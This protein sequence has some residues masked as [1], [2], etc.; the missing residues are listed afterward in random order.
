MCPIASKDMDEDDGA[1]EA[2]ALNFQNAAEA[3][4]LVGSALVGDWRENPL[5]ENR[6]CKSIQIW[7][8]QPIPAILDGETVS[9]GRIIEAHYDPAVTRV[10]AP[11]RSVR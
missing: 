7:S 4:Q 8:S 3:L 6:P 2:A 1:L 11:P 9:L 5:V 10:L